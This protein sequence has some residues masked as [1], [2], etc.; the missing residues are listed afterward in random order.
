ME[1]DR[2]AHLSAGGLPPALLALGPGLWEHVRGR[3]EQC[4]GEFHMQ[5]TRVGDSPLV[6]FFVSTSQG[7]PEQG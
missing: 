4:S 6:P 1:H 3:G 7:G 2:E 5:A